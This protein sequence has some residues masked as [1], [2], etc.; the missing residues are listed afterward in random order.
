MVSAKLLGV[1]FCSNLKFDEH[2]K[3]FDYLFTALL[4]V[5]IL[6]KGQGLPAKQLNVVFCAIVMSR[7]LN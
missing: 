5:E 1:T 2:V 3:H 4:L 7:I 6:K